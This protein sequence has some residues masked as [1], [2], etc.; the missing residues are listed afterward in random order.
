MNTPQQIEHA[1][2]AGGYA[3][4]ASRGREACPRYGITEDARELRD[5]WLRGWDAEDRKRRAA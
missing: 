5:A 3:R 2:E 1:I 4:Q